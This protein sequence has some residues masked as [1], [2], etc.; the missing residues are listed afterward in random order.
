MNTKLKPSSAFQLF[1]SQSANADELNFVPW[2]LKGNNKRE[3]QEWC[4]WT[5]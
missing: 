5:G 1:V 3:D 2:Q 4:H